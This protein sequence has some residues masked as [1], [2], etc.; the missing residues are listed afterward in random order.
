MIGSQL[1]ESL[2]NEEALLLLLIRHGV[3]SLTAQE[4]HLATSV[5]K[6]HLSHVVWLV[7]RV[8]KPE[9]ANPVGV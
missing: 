6:F 7:D 5:A 9:T 1:A 2:P 3:L 8:L 4:E